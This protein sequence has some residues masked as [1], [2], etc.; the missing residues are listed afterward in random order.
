MRADFGELPVYRTF[1][2]RSRFGCL[3]FGRPVGPS[4]SVF[5]CASRECTGENPNTSR[6]LFLPVSGFSGLR[7][8][9]KID[10]FT[11]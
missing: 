3:V 9:A 2:F 1:L 10:L 4:V 11:F 6:N 5:G 8:R 7:R